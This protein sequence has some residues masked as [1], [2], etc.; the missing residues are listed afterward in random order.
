MSYN[1]RETLSTEG[2][3]FR[4]FSNT[5]PN[6]SQ[7]L[8]HVDHD[9]VGMPRGRA[10][11]Q[12][13]HQPAVFFGTGFEF[14]SSAEINQLGIDRFALVQPLQQFDR[15]KTN[16]PVLDI[17]D[18][19]V[20]GFESISRFQFDE[21]VGPDDLKVRAERADLAV[22]VWAANLS[23]DYGNNPANAVADIAG[24]GHAADMRRDG[25]DESGL[26]RR[27]HRSPQ[28]SR[29]EQRIQ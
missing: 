18:R 27:R 3:N 7:H 19:A 8:M 10:D 13:L 17:N 5:H 15:S 4:S 14:G 6:F 29:Q 1:Y 20:V 16:S 23:S 24:R 25:E 9:P 21:L 2:S 12:V 28:A 26:Q 11:K 22:D